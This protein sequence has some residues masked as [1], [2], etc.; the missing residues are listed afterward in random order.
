LE[1]VSALA[2]AF[3]I[4]TSYLLNV[5]T[6]PGAALPTSVAAV[7]RSICSAAARSIVA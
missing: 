5:E 4:D 7:F 6:S 1:K 2:D 3:L